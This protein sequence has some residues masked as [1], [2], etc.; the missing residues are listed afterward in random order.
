M[1]TIKYLRGILCMGVVVVTGKMVEL[2]H[3]AS[4][5]FGELN[6]LYQFIYLYGIFQNFKFKAYTCWFFADGVNILTGLS[7]GGTDKDG[8]HIHDRNLAVNFN[9]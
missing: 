9:M 6:P 3:L 7:Y 2:D 1:G 4:D 5:E 8:N